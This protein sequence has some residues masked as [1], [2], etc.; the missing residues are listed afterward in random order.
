MTTFTNMKNSRIQI[1]M[2]IILIAALLFA[3]GTACS[4]A[5]GSSSSDSD[6][7]TMML[8]SMGVLS[9]DSD[10]SYN[11]SKTV[12]RAEFAK[13]IVM[14]SNY[15][16]LVQTTSYSSPYKDVPAKNWAAPYVRLAVSNGLMSG[17]SDGTFRPNSTIT[18]EQGVNSVLLLLGY[19]QS[20]FTGAFPYAQMNVYSNNG[21]SENIVGGIGTYMT[22][23]DAAN[24]I[25]NLMGTTMKD[26]SGTYSE[27]LG[28]SLN[29]SGEVNYAEIISDNMNGPYTVKS[30]NWASELGMDA[31]SLTI[32]RNGSVI[33]AS[34]V[35]TYDVL[36]YSQSKGTVWAYDD[37]VTG[38]YEDA[39]PSQNAVTTV[40][41]SG[42]EY[43]LES[44]A[45]FS[46][47]SSTGTLKVGSA[48]TLLLGKSGGVA[49]AVSSTVVNESVA[50][51]VTETGSKTYTNSSG[52]EYTS[53][54]FKGIKPNGTEIEYTTTQDWIEPGAM[55]KINF[56]SSGSMTIGSANL[57][58]NISG[59]V[60]A[61]LCLIGDTSISSNATI[62]DTNLGNYAKTSLQ[63]LDGVR[64]QSGDVLYYE[65]SGGKV[66][67]LILNDVTGD[68]SEYGVVTSAN[69]GDSSGT[70][71]YMVG[72]VSSTLSTSDT[73]LG[74]NT[75]AAKFYGESG[76]ISMI[77]NLSSVRKVKT[78][79]GS[80]I[81]VNDDIGTYPISADVAVYTK[82]GDYKVSTL[83][84]AMTA[85]QAKEMVTFYYDKAPKEGGCVRVIVY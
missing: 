10:G 65:A 73:T 58:S 24:L 53:L 46:A 19:T 29:D 8:A 56:S 12:T 84:A 22:K 67:T 70:Y 51:Y 64:F 31:S 33:S 23:G 48:V 79:S 2:V 21:L 26:G 78:F 1:C 45:A 71:G 69:S 37:K 15:K 9:A 59:A 5:A 25:Y 38:I 54:Y 32:Y 16:D 3:N 13:M 76:E 11:L 17:Y 50:V 18:L 77:R 75:G 55:L 81:T 35:E 42:T 57:G 72:G 83:S 44:A 14:A 74:V 41:V 28:Y 4:Y 40:T 61:G 34:D 60:D 85:Y 52:T 39:S 47:L 62:L 36:Y 63:R 80:Q 6:T 27:S 43:T 7:A 68:T 66:T 20:D 82:S 30:G 49:D